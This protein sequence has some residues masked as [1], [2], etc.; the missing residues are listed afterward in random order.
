MKPVR[1]LVEKVT[2][3]FSEPVEKE[4]TKEEAFGD[5]VDFVKQKLG[6]KE[7]N[8]RRSVLSLQKQRTS[9]FEGFSIR[10]RMA[11][12]KIYNRTRKGDKT[13]YGKRPKSKADRKQKRLETVNYFRNKYGLH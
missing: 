1:V 3:F 7:A 10:D 5:F 9:F 4:P 2:S 11:T 13:I 8:G 12:S 6:V